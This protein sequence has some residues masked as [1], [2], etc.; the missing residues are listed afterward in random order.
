MSRGT[1]DTSHLVLPFAYAAITL[2][3]LPFQVVQ[4]DLTRLMPVLNPSGIAAA[5]LGS[6]HFAR[7]YSGNLV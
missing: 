2:C 5:G 3:S 7:R 6:S 4:L 1:L